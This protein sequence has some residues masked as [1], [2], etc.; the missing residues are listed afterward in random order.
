MLA[1]VLPGSGP[2][3]IWQDDLLDKVAEEYDRAGDKA[4]ASRFRHLLQGARAIA[5]DGDDPTPWVVERIPEIAH[6][7]TPTDIGM[8]WRRWRTLAAEFRK[9]VKGDTLAGRVREPA[10]WHSIIE[11]A[12]ERLAQVTN[13]E[14]SIIKLA[15]RR[16]TEAERL[17]V[18]A[19]PRGRVRD[20][21]VM[22]MRLLSAACRPTGE[23]IEHFKRQLKRYKPGP[24]P[25][26]APKAPKPE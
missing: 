1:F 15:W 13:D 24:V 25:L 10:G 20:P 19:T 5:A 26:T 4:K 6:G 14:G 16:L 9:V 23:E 8:Y 18:I 21:E 12:E 2:M 3:D 17:E 11:R 22:A 7:R